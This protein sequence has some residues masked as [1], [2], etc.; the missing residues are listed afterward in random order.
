[1]RQAGRVPV[2]APRP[3]TVTTTGRGPL[4]WLLAGLAVVVIA[5]VAAVALLGGDDAEV[6]LADGTGAG[7]ATEGDAEAGAE[8]TVTRLEPGE[9]TGRCMTPTAEALAQ[10][11]FAFEGTV[12]G[13]DDGVA[14]LEPV[15]F[16]AGR[17]TDRV[18]VAAPTG[19]QQALIGSVALEEGAR[20]LVAAADGRVVGCGLS[21]RAE[22]DL[23]EMY[24]EAFNR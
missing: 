10:Q 6:P 24:A 5:V 14:V 11:P 22:P 8:P 12:V 18:E 16:F 15:E 4:T 19:S 1:M 23:A 21:G 17:A 2:D 20:Y 3:E 9:E 13:I 7:S